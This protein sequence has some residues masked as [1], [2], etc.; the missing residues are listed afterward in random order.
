MEYFTI[1]FNMYLVAPLCGATLIT[2]WLQSLFHK[3]RQVFY[4][5]LAVLAVWTIGTYITW[6]YFFPSG[7]K[8]AVGIDAVIQFVFMFFNPVMV[9]VMFVMRRSDSPQPNASNPSPKSGPFESG[10]PPS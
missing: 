4:K 1:I 5:G 8:D 7:A 2:L 3:Q 10:R 6:A 9:W